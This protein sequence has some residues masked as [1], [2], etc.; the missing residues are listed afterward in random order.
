MKILGLFLVEVV[1]LVSVI[2]QYYTWIILASVMISWVS[3]D[4]Y[5]PIVRFLRQITEPVFY[6]VR[7]LMPA[8]LLRTGIDFSPMVVLL[9][10]MLFRNVVLRVLMEVGLE[11]HHSGLPG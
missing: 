1:Q 9:L 7:R 2:L 10:I 5:N 4:P 6:Q 3:P 11:F 8:A